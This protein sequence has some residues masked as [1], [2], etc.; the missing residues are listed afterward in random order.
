[1]SIQLIILASNICVLLIVSVT[2]DYWEYRGFQQKEIETK[3]KRCQPHNST[4]LIDPGDT[5]SYL[6]IQYYWNPR[7]KRQKKPAGT[8]KVLHYQPP[9]LV[10]KY[11]YVRN[12][13]FNVTY[14][15]K[16]DN[17]TEQI[18][19]TRIHRWQDTI[20]LYV[21]Y[22]NLFRECDSLEGK[23]SH[24]FFAFIHINIQHVPLTTSFD[25][26]FT[27]IL[28]YIVPFAFIFLPFVTPFYHC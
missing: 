3:V 27:I 23:T 22:G 15:D 4:T 13:T 26:C 6:Q 8:K 14:Y 10:Y 16:D 11:Y 25:K 21:Q 24:D 9:A 12:H 17:Y 5:D 7:A 28:F 2:T 18:T 1:M 20:I 19:E